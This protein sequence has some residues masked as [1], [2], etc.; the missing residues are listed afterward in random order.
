[1]AETEE[2]Q[3]TPE[4]NPEEKELIETAESLLYSD[5][6]KQLGGLPFVVG[7]ARKLVYG[8][9]VAMVAH[10]RLI[11]EFSPSSVVEYMKKEEPIPILEDEPGFD[12]I[13]PPFLIVWNYINGLVAP[14]KESLWSTLTVEQFKRVWTYANRLYIPLSSDFFVLWAEGMYEALENDPRRIKPDVRKFVNDVLEFNRHY[15]SLQKNNKHIALGSL[16][17]LVPYGYEFWLIYGPTSEQ[18][19]PEYLEYDPC[20]SPGLQGSVIVQVERLSPEGKVASLIGVFPAKYT[21]RVE[22]K[23]T[24]L[25]SEEIKAYPEPYVASGR[26]PIPLG[27]SVKTPAVEID[28]GTRFYLAPH[29]CTKEDLK[30]YWISPT[31]PGERF[32]VRFFANSSG[33]PPQSFPEAKQPT[34]R[35]KRPRSAYIL[36]AQ[37]ARP[38]IIRRFP[39]IGSADIGRRLGEWWASLTPEQKAPYEALAA[40]KRAEYE[41]AILANE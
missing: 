35:G 38:E 18:V 24:G 41:E 17:L 27:G 8:L 36:F 31:Y 29:G 30:K 2:S 5:E 22:A 25:T 39:E 26:L 34:R 16:E 7:T 40:A 21:G 20:G 28:N 37:H 12:E 10:S 1:M 9:Y 23:D 32:R 13:N 15:Q 3:E 19:P 33:T 4:V 6:M 11:S 14:D